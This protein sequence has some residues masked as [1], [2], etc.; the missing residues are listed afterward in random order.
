MRSDN[1][2]A[3]PPGLPVPVD[4]GAA[5]HLIGLPLPPIAL[6]S[7]LGGEIRLDDPSAPLTIVF[8]YPRTGLPDQDAPGGRVLW[9]AIPGARGC[10]PQC[11]AYRDRFDELAATGAR[12]FG[13]STQTTGYQR[14]LVC[15]L[16]L[17]YPILSDASLEFTRAVRLP[18][19]EVEGMTLLRRLTFVAV[20]GIITDCI[21][22][23]FPPDRDAGR[24]LELIR[25][26]T[27][28][29]HDRHP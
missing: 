21:Y 16:G 26:R 19:F 29:L 23:V 11:L 28:D 6:P 2:Y 7:T 25:S 14:E 9:D 10:T 13:L 27:A 8:C 22:P 1:L 3:L 18:A 24:V 5:S 20:S 12:L 17:P 15:R 4:D